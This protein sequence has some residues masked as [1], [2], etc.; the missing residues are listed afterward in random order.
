MELSVCAVIVLL[1][2]WWGSTLAQDVIYYIDEELPNS[3]YIGNVMNDSNLF[4]AIGG[5]DSNT[6][7]FSTTDTEYAHYFRVNERTSDLYT[8]GNIDREIICEFSETCMIDIQIFA[9]ST[10]GSFF[11]ILKI[12][13]FINDVNDHSPVFSR[14]TL[15]L[16]ISESVLV[17]T[18][19][20]IDGAQDRDTSPEFSLR[21]YYLES[22]METNNL[23]FSIQFVKHLDGSSTVRLF[24][25]EALDRETQ[26][27]YIFEII[28]ADADQPPRRGKLLV[29]VRVTDVNDNVPT[30]DSNAYNCTVTEETGISSVIIK[31]N[32]TDR[33]YGDNGL[34]KYKL[35]EHQSADIFALFEIQENTGEIRVKQK[36][37]YSPG[38]LYNIIVEAYDNPT[39]G[40]S[41]ATQT[42]VRVIVVNSG[43][44]A[45]VIKI[46]LLSKT[47]AAEV[48]ENA[49]IGTVVAYVVV[50]DHDVGKQGMTSCII[51]AIDFDLQRIDMNR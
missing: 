6:L 27:T 34:I 15:T 18:S 24:V 3:T 25:T 45:P 49:N 40:Q 12:N 23:P 42:L 29:T 4:S 9:K 28:A 41:H 32:A 35:S 7:I 48:W 16:P 17:G 37:V 20:A 50:E 36:V 10:L 14:P 22:G 46:N 38:K 31:L 11:H 1:V 47:S 13:I 39:V 8:N 5:A 2:C 33:D 26:D 51:Q 43:N 21:Q 19:F 44:N 30:F